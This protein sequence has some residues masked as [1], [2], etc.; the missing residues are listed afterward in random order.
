MRALK[1]YTQPIVNVTDS[2]LDVLEL[3]LDNRFDLLF[4]HIVYAKGHTVPLGHSTMCD[5]IFRLGKTKA[6]ERN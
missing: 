3:F 5:L 1:V 4:D 6:L 2:S